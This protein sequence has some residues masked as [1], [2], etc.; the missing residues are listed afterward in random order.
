MYLYFISDEEKRG[1]T[2]KYHI[3]TSH[4]I[5]IYNIMNN[6][7]Y[8]CNNCNKIYSCYR[9]LWA[10]N[11]NHH[12]GDIKSVKNEIVEEKHKT[13]ECIKC[14]KKY[15]HSQS[16][17]CHEKNCIGITQRSLELEVEQT[18][19]EVEKMKQENKRIDIEALKL[20]IKLQGMKKITNK[21]FKS[22]NKF[23]MDRSTI[24]NTMNNTIN[25]NHYHLQ[26]M[27]LGNE[28][29]LDSLSLQEKKSILDRRLYS[30]ET[31]VEMVHCGKHNMFKNIIITNL[32]DK[33]AYRYDEGKGYFITTTKKDVL[34][35][36]VA[37]RMMDIEA[38]YD[39]L[40]S[41]NKIDSKTKKLIQQFLDKM[42]NE[43]TYVNDEI[44]YKNFKSYKT[45]NIKILLYNNQDKMT[46][47]IALL[48]G[49]SKLPS[50]ETI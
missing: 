42:E 23:L 37:N 9:T 8:Q 6:T 13:F 3:K 32:K 46:K 20:K 12:N 35:D 7:K 43:D 22:I 48:I 18:R 29:L 25:N 21:T 15:K 28:N 40:S 19:L 50:Q 47:D 14:N 10:H 39:E 16:R 36:L 30:L 26:I 34:D 24:N 44:E 5:Y 45:N 49:D 2:R 11:K 33:F 38:I 1:K 41:A 4:L 17:N 27:A 31:M